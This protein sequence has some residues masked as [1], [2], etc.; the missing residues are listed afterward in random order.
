[1]AASLLLWSPPLTANKA[2][3]CGRW[4]RSPW[5]PLVGTEGA[6]APFWS[7]DSRAVAFSRPDKLQQIAIATGEVRT[8]HEGLAIGGSW[9]QEGVILFS[10]PSGIHRVSASGGAAV[11]VTDAA[12]DNVGH[13]WPAFLPTADISSFSKSAARSLAFI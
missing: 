6:F 2:C 13:M 3:G 5:R 12:R 7:W 4:I 8:I 9:N 11:A 10:D 1:M